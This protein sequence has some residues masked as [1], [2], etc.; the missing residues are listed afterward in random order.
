MEQRSSSMDENQSS[1]CS[2]ELIWFG[3]GFFQPLYR[4]DFYRRVIRRRVLPAVVFFVV[5]GVLLA[6]LSTF[7]VMWE[8][9]TVNRG[10]QE[11]FDKDIFPEIVIENGVASVDAR[12]PYVISDYEGGIFVLDTTGEYKSID[13]SRYS[14]GF[15]LTRY[16]AHLLS[17]GDYRVV[18]LSDLHELLGTNPIVIDQDR[19]VRLW[20]GFSNLIGIVV[21]AGLG[22]WNV[23]VWFMFMCFLAVIMWGVASVMQRRTEFGEMLI[24]GLYAY[25]PATYVQILLWLIT[26][27]FFAL[28]TLLLL[29]IW[30]FLVYRL[31]D[32]KS[33]NDLNLN[34]DSSME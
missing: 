17:E 20:Q 29:L 31:F 33:H 21:L 23:V 28:K 16:E 24:L 32:V 10:I 19:A 25:V 6:L 14:Q 12:Q 8:M 18:A 5:F 3:R 2:G 26:I 22:F 13:R 4:L 27:R 15:L 9:R 7:N 30:G 1:G 11:A 34:Q